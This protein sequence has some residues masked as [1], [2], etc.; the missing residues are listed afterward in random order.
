MSDYTVEERLEGCWRG[1]RW[2]S[3]FFDA[4]IVLIPVLLLMKLSFFWAAL[5][6]GTVWGFP[7]LKAFF[8]GGFGAALTGPLKADYEVVTYQ[9]GVRVSSDGGA[10]SMQT[11]FLVK[12]LLLGA[13]WAFAL[14]AVP[15][16]V[17]FLSVKGIIL[18]LRAKTKPPFLKSVFFIM[19]INVA[20]LISPTVF[21]RIAGN[22][23]KSARGVTKS[24]DYQYAK[25]LSGDG[26]IIEDYF[27]ESTG[28]LIIPA[29]IDGL[30]VVMIKNIGTRLDLTSVVIPEGVTDIGYALFYG[31]D[32]LTSVTFPS[33]IKRMGGSVFQANTSIVE[34]KIPQG[35]K[36]TYGSYLTSSGDKNDHQIAK[37]I[38][39]EDKRPLTDAFKGAANLSET[40]KQAIRDSGYTGDF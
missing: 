12:L 7:V 26:I 21:V 23:D 28:D 31:F 30:P 24:G 36:I 14:F 18:H 8:L 20:V 1:L 19:I 40:S 25:T 33:T 17:F 13:V 39:F 35:T 4:G 15:I 11:N 5:I 29:Q 34:V 38:F 2:N 10:Q 22:A 9:D 6:G 3:I 27:G 16:H 32:E 37:N